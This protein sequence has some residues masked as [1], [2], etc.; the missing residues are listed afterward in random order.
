MVLGDG[1]AQASDDLGLFEPS[2]GILDPR[3]RV[4]R[5]RHLWLASPNRFL[6]HLE[7]KQTQLPQTAAFPGGCFCAL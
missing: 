6:F 1:E 2:G 4:Y 5:L 3:C 7:Q